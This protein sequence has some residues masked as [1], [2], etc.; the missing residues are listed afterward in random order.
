LTWQNQALTVYLSSYDVQI[1]E[2]LIEMNVE[3]IQELSGK[4]PF[5]L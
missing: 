5:F 3:G 2:Q 1:S 4:K